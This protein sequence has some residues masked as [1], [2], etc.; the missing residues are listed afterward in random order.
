MNANPEPVYSAGVNCD[1]AVEANGFNFGD[2][3]A[4]LQAAQAQ[5]RTHGNIE[6]IVRG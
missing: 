4:E 2:E 3:Q 1:P 6:W 5:R